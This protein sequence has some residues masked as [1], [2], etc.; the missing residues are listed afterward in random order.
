MQVPR[1]SRVAQTVPGGSTAGNPAMAEGVPIP[2]RASDFAAT[3][4]H[5]AAHRSTKP[6][7]DLLQRP[8]SGDRM[9]CVCAQ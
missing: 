5:L 9:E 1:Q 2:I 6:R 7:A 3:R 8:W 4:P